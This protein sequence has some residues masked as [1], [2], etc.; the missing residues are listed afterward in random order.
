[1]AWELRGD[2]RG[3]SAYDVAVANG[4][5]GTQAEWLDSLKG[6]PGPEQITVS[7]TAPASPYLNQLWLD[8]S[9][10]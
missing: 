9:G 8:T 4:F 10:A 1:M 6:E 3:I 7:A 5:T 2:L